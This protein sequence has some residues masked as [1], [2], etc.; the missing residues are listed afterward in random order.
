MA[1]L[2]SM[3]CQTP[4]PHFVPVTLPF[5]LMLLNLQVRPFFANDSTAKWLMFSDVWNAI[6]E[7]LRSVDLLCDLERDY[8]CFELLDMD[9]SIEVR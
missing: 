7:E 6:V 8:L 1:W 3:V 4:V 2:Q 9:E 5:S